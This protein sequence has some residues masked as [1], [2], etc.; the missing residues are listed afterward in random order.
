LTVLVLSS[1][2]QKLLQTSWLLV[3]ST[4]EVCPMTKLIE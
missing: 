3:L 1:V 2:F 4:T